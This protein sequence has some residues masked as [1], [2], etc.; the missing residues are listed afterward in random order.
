VGGARPAARAADG[1][2]RGDGAATALGGLALLADLSWSSQL[3]P[4]GIMWGM[5]EAV[6]LAVYFL[7]SA[8]AG[9]EVLPPLILAWGGMCT[10][11]AFL[12][13]AG[14]AGALRL[15]A[16]AGNA[17]LLHHRASWIVPVLEL[18][19]VSAAI[20]YVAG[21]AAAR[22]LGARLASMKPGGGP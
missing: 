6:S 17:E 15:T 4:V 21:V 3:N 9:E 8:A 5:L 14:G 22:R 13:L 20:A 12:G 1:R 16:N 18:S 11:A 10:G 7:L 19:L 2:R